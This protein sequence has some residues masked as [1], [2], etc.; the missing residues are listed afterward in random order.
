[1]L[2]WFFEIWISFVPSFYSYWIY[3]LLSCF[4][5]HVSCTYF[6]IKINLITDRF[7]YLAEFVPLVFF[8]DFW[9]VVWVTAG[10]SD[11]VSSIFSSPPPPIMLNCILKQWGSLS[12][13]LKTES[14]KFLVRIGQ[15]TY[16][17]DV[18]GES[19]DDFF[20]HLIAPSLKSLLSGARDFKTK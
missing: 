12:R 5:L 4:A 13:K 7:P 2:F 17:E 8:P 15:D 3:M 18:I 1:M 19:I 9:V 16:C 6:S 20:L 10:D 11:S 14:V